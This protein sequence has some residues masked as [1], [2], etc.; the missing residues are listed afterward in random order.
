MTDAPWDAPALAL[1][2]SAP[3]T[4]PFPRPPFVRT[5][6]RTWAP[7]TPLE[8]VAVDDAALVLVS[9]GGTIEIAGAPELTDYHS[10]LGSG[11]ADLGVEIAERFRGRPFRF[12]SLPEEAAAALGKG[13]RIGG[14]QVDSEQHHVTAVVELPE[15][16]EAWLF[17]IG[18]KHRHEVR[19]KRRRFVDEIGEPTLERHDEDAALEAFFAMHRLSAGEKGHFMTPRMARFFHALHETVGAVV[20][21]LVVEGRPVAATFSFEEDDA[22]YVYNSAYDPAAAHASP[23]IVMLSLLIEDRIRRGTRIFDLLKGDERY[24]FQHGAEPRPLFVLEG[25]L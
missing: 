23:G 11:V 17:M 8:V 1:D 3:F 9:R 7:E 5:W 10:P 14:A 13:L 19:R 18:K 24:K 25:I 12:D 21:L 15:T 16:F 20:D 4:G 22:F 6:Q 2:P